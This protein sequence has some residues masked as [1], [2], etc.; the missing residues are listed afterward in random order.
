MKLELRNIK[1]TEFAS[2]ETNCFEAAL[3]VDDEPLAVLSNDGRGGADMVH[4][5]PKAKVAN[6]QEFDQRIAAVN[7]HLIR[8]NP[9]YEAFGHKM[10]YDLELWTGDQITAWLTEKDLKKG[11]KSRVLFVAPDKDGIRE[12]RFKGVRQITEQHITHVEKKYPTARILNRLPFAE[13]LALYRKTVEK[14]VSR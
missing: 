5:H 12:V 1:H 10:D 2:E 4:K 9:D 14:G 7:A 11:L 6:R 8:S 13:A 3:W